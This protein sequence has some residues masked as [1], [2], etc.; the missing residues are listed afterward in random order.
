MCTHMRTHTLMML[1]YNTGKV[2]PQGNQSLHIKKFS[3]RNEV[4]LW[5]LLTSDVSQTANISNCCPYH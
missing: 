3:V 4:L 5:V 1:S 2:P